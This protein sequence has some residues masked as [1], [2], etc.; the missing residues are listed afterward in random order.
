MHRQRAAPNRSTWQHCNAAPFYEHLTA[1]EEGKKN[2]ALV[3]KPW[4]PNRSLWCILI[5]AADGLVAIVFSLR[6]CLLASEMVA[7]ENPES[8]TTLL[9]SSLFLLVAG[10]ALL[11]AIWLGALRSYGL[12]L[13]KFGEEMYVEKPATD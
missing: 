4:F 6:D 3:A 8:I 9:E 12:L 10:I 7:H 11:S 5:L 13:R 2:H 1:Y